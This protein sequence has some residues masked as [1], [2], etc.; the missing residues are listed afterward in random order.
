MWK[1]VFL[2]ILKQGAL[3]VNKSLINMKAKNVFPHI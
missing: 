2:Y 3:Q 1:Q